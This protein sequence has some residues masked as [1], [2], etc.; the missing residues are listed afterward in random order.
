MPP[1]PRAN[2]H[3]RGH[4]GAVSAL[5]QAVRSGRLHHGWLLAGPP[6]IG[7]A[8]LAFRFARWLLEGAETPDLYVPETAPVF[9]RVAAGTHPDLFTVERRINAKTEKL[10]S[11]IVIATIQEAFAAKQKRLPPQVFATLCVEAYHEA[12]RNPG[13]R[14]AALVERLQPFIR[15]A[16]AGAG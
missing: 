6:G 16:L 1:E 15:L 11:E 4:E 3:F 10:Q 2:P 12:Q 8:T 13:L 14:G 7:K 9:R 5:Y